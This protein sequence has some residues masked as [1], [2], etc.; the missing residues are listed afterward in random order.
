MT[1]PPEPPT[2]TPPSPD[3]HGLLLPDGSTVDVAP[4]GAD[5]DDAATARAEPSRSPYSPIAVIARPVRRITKVQAIALVVF[6]LVSL[7]PILALIVVLR[8]DTTTVPVV[9]DE[10]PITAEDGLNLGLTIT[11]VNAVTR[12]VSIRMTVKSSSTGPTGLIEGGRMTETVDIGLPASP[13]SLQGDSTVTLEK[14]STVSAVEFMV[15][16]TNGSIAR[17]PYDTYEAEMLIIASR[18]PDGAASAGTAGGVGSATTRSG[19]SGTL[20]VRIPVP[21]SVKVS[22][23]V[24]GYVVEGQ[25][26][27]DQPAS[28]RSIVLDV[29]RNG[30]TLLYTTWIMLLWWALSLS[31][32]F[33]VWSVSIWRT[34]APAWAYGYLVGVLFSLAPLRGALPG[35]PPPGVLIDY[36]SFYWAVGTVGVGLVLLVSFFVRDARQDGR[37]GASSTESDGDPDDPDDPNVEPVSAPVEATT[38]LPVAIGTEPVVTNDVV[39]RPSDPTPTPTPTSAS[40]SAPHDHPRR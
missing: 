27:A 24:P 4:E 39:A 14:G 9:V 19:E 11:S 20:P 32:V 17:Y 37:S 29:R 1:A 5:R 35:Q 13:G 31:A 16:L 38:S 22:A 15:Q 12:E 36:V 34:S 23:D 10:E 33:I 25:L 40:D 3:E 6:T 30:P 8:S 7:G 21:I 2:P 26:E 28:N 18:A